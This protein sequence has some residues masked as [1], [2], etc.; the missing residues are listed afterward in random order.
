MSSLV[1]PCPELPTPLRRY[2]IMAASM[3]TSDV[4][5]SVNRMG[6]AIDVGTFAVKVKIDKSP[7]SRSEPGPAG[8][9]LD[10]TVPV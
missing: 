2:P 9:K 5:A 8:S 3:P 1:P 10:A 7:P 6:V 4:V